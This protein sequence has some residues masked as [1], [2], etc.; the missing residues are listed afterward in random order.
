MSNTE[1]KYSFLRV[2]LILATI[3]RLQKRINERFPHSGLSK[4]CAELIA[5]GEKNKAI[6][7][8]LKGPCQHSD[9]FNVELL[10]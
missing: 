6:I 5:E 4:V 8:E 1:G 2:D 7:E 9:K 3:Y 10:R